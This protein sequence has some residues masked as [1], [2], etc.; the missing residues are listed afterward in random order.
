MV[1]RR[2][3]FGREVIAAFAAAS[4]HVRHA[5]DLGAG[6]GDDLD[7]VR[8][9]HPAAAL[10]GVEVHP[11][12]ARDLRARGIA[13]LAL[14]L[15][16]EALPLP[17]ASMDLIIANQFLEHVKELF[18]IMHE[19]S[20]T[21]RPGG[22]LLIGVPNLASL[23]NRLLLALGRQP[24]SIRVASAH[25][26]GFTARGLLAFLED[27]FPGGY[28]LCARRGANFY[29]FPPVIARPMARMC[30][31]LAWGLFLHL[32][33]AR[34]YDGSFVRFPVDAALE[35]NYRTSAS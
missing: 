7:S 20:R 15:E 18:W 3:N 34:P 16:R 32:R 31:G 10:T 19:V 23:H 1:D 30:P 13:V 5:L 22:H 11:A 12:C 27:G 21:L 26:R 9:A 33:K 29:P 14:D 28:V 35:T 4:D 24:T 2:L 8:R 17:D 6:A 25:V